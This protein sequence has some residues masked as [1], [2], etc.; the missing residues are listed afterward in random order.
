MRYLAAAFVA[1]L[2]CVVAL[3][4]NAAAQ[5]RVEIVQVPAPSLAGNRL[6][7]A[8]EQ[9]AAVYL[10]PSYHAATGR[11]Y[12]VIYLLHGIFDS[13][14]TWLEY[15]DLAERLDRLIAAERIPEVIVM[16]PDGGNIYGGGFYRNS[17]V[18]GKWGDFVTEDLVRFTDSRYRTLARAGGRAIA[19]WSMGGY[20]AIHLAMG[21]PGLYSVVYAI[22]PC[23]LSP[24]E[25]LGFGND[26]W[27]RAYR[28]ENEADLAAAMEARD[29]YAVAG[30]GVLTAFSPAPDAAPFFVDFPFVVERGQVVPKNGVFDA[31][32]ARFPLS[33]VAQHR[34]AL[35]GLRAFGIDYGVNDQ[36]AHIPVATR[37]FSLRLAELR[38]PHRL[39]VYDGDHRE[40]VAERME[41]TV[42]PFIGAA[43]DPPQQ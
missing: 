12:P 43:L 5:G 35:A 29:F 8:P 41:T 15:V 36:Y 10:P 20:G 23:C 3:S 4:G 16:M 6:G 30:I 25:D 13:H 37:E 32:V 34:D 39:D 2:V 40:R 9:T 31:Y 24:V 11:R 27:Q 33:R 22:S 7:T 38:I 19:G 14:E 28:F 21:H 42:L 26:A 1:M 18:S 17:P